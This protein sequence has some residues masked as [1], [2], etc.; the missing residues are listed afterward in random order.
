MEGETM[1]AAAIDATFADYRTVKTRKVLQLILE[2]PIE[3]QAEVFEILGFPMPDN[4]PW[5]AVARL[6]R[7]LPAE[8]KPKDES[9]SERAKQAF[10]MKDGGEKAVTRSILLCKTM[11]FQVWFE[12][13]CAGK[14]IVTNGQPGEESTG[15]LLRQYLN[16]SSRRAI[17]AG[18]DAYQD[19]LALETA[20]KQATGQMAEERR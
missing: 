1:T 19:F 8:Q 11:G 3:R 13:H 16:I 9:R 20:Y 7:D 12:R 10:A 17:G 15:E 2:V 5:L 14:G 18:E 4:P 6:K